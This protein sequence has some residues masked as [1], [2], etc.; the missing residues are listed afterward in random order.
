MDSRVTEIRYEKRPTRRVTPVISEL[1]VKSMLPT[2]PSWEG[3]ARKVLR[4]VRVRDRFQRLATGVRTRQPEIAERRRVIDSGYS[5]V[6]RDWLR[7]ETLPQ[8]RLW[9]LTELFAKY[10]RRKLIKLETMMWYV[11]N[12]VLKWRFYPNVYLKMRLLTME[13]RGWTVSERKQYLRTQR[14]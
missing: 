6:F 10:I 13:V 12:D 9:K 1:A 14:R 3:S 7:V 2:T 5:V 8:K 11:M 4:E